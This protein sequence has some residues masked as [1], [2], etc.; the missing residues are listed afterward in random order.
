MLCPVSAVHAI[1]N[2]NG[3]YSTYVKKNSHWL[4]AGPSYV[5]WQFWLIAGQCNSKAN[6]WKL[7]CFFL[8]EVTICMG[9]EFD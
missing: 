2:Y 3:M 8:S 4:Y 7:L 9:D 5:I 6:Q 1:V